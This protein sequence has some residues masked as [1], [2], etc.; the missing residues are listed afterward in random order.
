MLKI[1]FIN[2]GRLSKLSSYFSMPRPSKIPWI[3]PSMMP[4]SNLSPYKARGRFDVFPRKI[5]DKGLRYGALNG[6][7]GC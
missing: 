2:L 6:V 7:H 3:A 4:V 1:V 5:S